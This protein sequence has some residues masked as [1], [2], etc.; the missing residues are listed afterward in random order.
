M[1]VCVFYKQTEHDTYRLWRDFREIAGL[2]P[3]LAFSIVFAY[4]PIQQNNSFVV[5]K[6]K[7]SPV[8]NEDKL[9]STRRVCT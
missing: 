7:Q 5:T 3:T 8:F 9:G 2:L 6:M 1:K 4:F